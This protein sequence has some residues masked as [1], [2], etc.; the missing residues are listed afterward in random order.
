VLQPVA[1]LEEGKLSRRI[2]RIE[3]GA[4]TLHRTHRLATQARLL[5]H[6]TGIMR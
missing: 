4:I 3:G 2:G 1:G 5:P 6:D